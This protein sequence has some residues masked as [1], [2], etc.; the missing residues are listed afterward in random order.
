MTYLLAIATLSALGAVLARRFAGGET[1]LWECRV[2]SP[3][4][5]R[6]ENST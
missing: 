3:G 6:E 1:G 4:L 5:V 2:T